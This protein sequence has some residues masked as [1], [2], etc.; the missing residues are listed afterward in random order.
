MQTHKK[1]TSTHA[2]F[3]QHLKANFPKSR[4]MIKSLCSL[5]PYSK[6]ALLP[7][8]YATKET[9]SNINPSMG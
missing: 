5:K 6:F 8:F 2:F 1:N 7:A 3:P 9:E 4:K